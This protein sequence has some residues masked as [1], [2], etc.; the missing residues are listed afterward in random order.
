MNKEV[1]L[2][3]LYGKC[4]NTIRSLGLHHDN[5]SI[6]TNYIYLTCVDVRYIRSKFN[7][8]QICREV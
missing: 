8:N 7:L 5:L 6:F 2:K 4:V 3:Q 1:T